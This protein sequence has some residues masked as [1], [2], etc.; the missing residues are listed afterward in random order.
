MPKRRYVISNGSGNA[1]GITLC[2]FL[3]STRLF[4]LSI[5][6][7][8]IVDQKIVF[9]AAAMFTLGVERVL[10]IPMESTAAKFSRSCEA[11]VGAKVCEVSI[12][13]HCTAHKTQK[14]GIYYA[15]ESFSTIN[16]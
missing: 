15:R 6:S 8:W 9:H 13:F 14:L 11:V 2:N 12:I 1:E 4:E 3:R 5:L 10:V 7:F 16:V